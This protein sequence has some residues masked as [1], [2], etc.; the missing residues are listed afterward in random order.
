VATISPLEFLG[1]FKNI[2][3]G[4]Y[5]NP[6]SL[7]D[8]LVESVLVEIDPEVAFQIGGDPFGSR[9][10]LS[11]TLSPTTIQLVDFYAPP[12]ADG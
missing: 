9:S 5:E 11:A 8:F 12:R 3:K 2:W 6:K 1:H 7:F 4:D 10:R